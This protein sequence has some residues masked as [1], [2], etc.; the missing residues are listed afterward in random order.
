MGENW[1]VGGGDIMW[2]GDTAGMADDISR[3]FV[4]MFLSNMIS[5]AI[6]KAGL[7]N[8]SCNLFSAFNEMYFGI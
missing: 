5:C 1:G 8:E 3:A 2:E 4:S 6:F 7:I